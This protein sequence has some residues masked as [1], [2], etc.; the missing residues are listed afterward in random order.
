MQISGAIQ[1]KWTKLTS[2]PVLRFEKNLEQTD[3]QT[4]AQ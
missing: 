1:A 4:D 3:R 2:L